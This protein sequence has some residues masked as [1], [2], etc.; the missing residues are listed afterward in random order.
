MPDIF[1]NYANQR[2]EAHPMIYAY[3]DANP[4]Y[5][6]LLKV[7]YTEVDVDKRVAQQYPTLHPG[8]KLPYKIVWRESAMYPD[9]SSFTDKDVHRVL[10]K[11]GFP[12]LKGLDGKKT[13]WFR[14]TLKDVKSAII[15]V[16]SHTLNEEN[17][18]QTFKMRPEQQTAVD[19]TEAYFKKEKAVDKNRTPK[20][21]WNAKMRFG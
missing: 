3:E 8:D 14:C 16:K 15:A 4:Q 5:S 21:L 17:R 9:G 20:F 10:T 6:D 12:N 2:P 13:E 18:T 7:G 1:D 11:H 19:M